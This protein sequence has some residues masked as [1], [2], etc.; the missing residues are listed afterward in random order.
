MGCY[1]TEK[2]YQSG[3]SQI[4]NYERTT[5]MVLI[6][7]ALEEVD[8]TDQHG[9]D[10]ASALRREE[11]FLLRGKLISNTIWMNYGLL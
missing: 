8:M 4:V 6:S 2:E 10:D 3:Y 9:V 1:A 5:K 11:A 7:L